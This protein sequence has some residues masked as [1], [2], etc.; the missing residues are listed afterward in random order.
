MRILVFCAV[1]LAL[2]GCTSARE[3]SF[4]RLSDPVPEKITSPR[5]VIDVV[6]YTN[7]ANWTN[8]PWFR[9]FDDA[10]DLP[11]Q[12][13]VAEGGWACRVDGGDWAMVPAGSMYSCETRWLRPRR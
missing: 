6:M 2:A 13:I 4:E 5:R 7:S 9:M 1:L 10:F 8:S 12:F 11:V 3:G